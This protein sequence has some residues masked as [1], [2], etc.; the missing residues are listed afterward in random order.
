[1]ESM[2]YKETQTPGQVLLLHGRSSTLSPEQA[3]PPVHERSLLDRPPP[4]LLL[5]LLQ[6][7]QFDH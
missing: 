7:S 4:Q 5:Q 1:M 2:C 6:D 3:L